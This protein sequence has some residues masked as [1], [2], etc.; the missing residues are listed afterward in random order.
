MAL[1]NLPH[2]RQALLKS[3]LHLYANRFGKKID[4]IIPASPG[5][6]RVHLKESIFYLISYAQNSGTS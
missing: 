2:L 4:A 6:L 5:L 3:H 1:I